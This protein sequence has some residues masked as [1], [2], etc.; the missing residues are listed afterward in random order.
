M[1]TVQVYPSVRSQ[2]LGKLQ[3]SNTGTWEKVGKLP[4]AFNPLDSPCHFNRK[5]TDS[6]LMSFLAS[7]YA[8]FLKLFYIRTWKT[9]DTKSLARHFL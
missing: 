3:Q 5:V 1:C 2:L 7:K 6:L 9:H 4:A 8:G